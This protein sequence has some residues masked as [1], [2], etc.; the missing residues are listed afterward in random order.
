[1]SIDE[2]VILKEKLEVF[3]VNIPWFVFKEL[4]LCCKKRKRKRKRKKDITFIH[5]VSVTHKF[6]LNLNI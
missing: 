6:Y 3:R 1:M 2:K 4:T 5:D